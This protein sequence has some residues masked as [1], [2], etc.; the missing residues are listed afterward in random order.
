MKTVTLLASR[1]KNHPFP[2]ISW[3]IRL[4]E[5][6][7]FSHV[8]LYFEED[9]RVYDA[10][11]DNIQYRSLEEYENIHKIVHKASINVKENEY[12]KMKGFFNSKVGKQKHY[13]CT[14]LGVLIPQLIRIISFNNIFLSNTSQWFCKL[15]WS[16]SEIVKDTIDF[17][18][19][20]NDLD[21]INR[22]IKNHNYTTEDIVEVFEKIAKDN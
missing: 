21:F 1:P 17:G 8:G 3:L 7:R 20:K 13:F 5:W 12:G 19:E 2:L 18:L 4:I 15:G 22:K 14:L 11:F 16:C 6:S 9:D 10:H